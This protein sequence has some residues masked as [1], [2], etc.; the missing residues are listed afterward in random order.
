MVAIVVPL[1]TR[2]ALSEDE[3]ISL[4]QLV[5]FL[6]GYDKYLIGPA[7]SPVRVDGFAFKP[8][9][10]KFFG[11]LAGI[12]NLWYSPQLFEAFRDYKFIFYYHLDCLV[13]SDQL[14]E[15]CAAD[16]DYIGPPWIPCADSPWV[17]RP[18]VGNGGFL[19][20]K[21]ESALKVLY[22]R[23]AMEPASY[24]RDLLARNS[25]RFLPCIRL[26]QR[27]QR[28]RRRPAVVDRILDAWAANENPGL[29]GLNSDL[30]WSDQA[31]NY[32]PGFKVASLE[33]GLRFGFEVAPRLCLQ[34]NGGRLP[35]G[36]HA[37]P[38]YDRAFW[39][40]FLVRAQQTDAVA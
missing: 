22:N 17:D 33:Q 15:W 30:F 16:L 23:Y 7:G 35:F 26:L 2:P 38:R 24:W 6:G 37:W 5:H 32:Y 40:P 12:N 10:R 36:C 4:R 29:S 11:S 3:Q 39:E 25:R 21:V 27:V 34:M 13:L 1:S 20:V 18:R 19:L 8:F 9:P 14:M 28:L 31:V